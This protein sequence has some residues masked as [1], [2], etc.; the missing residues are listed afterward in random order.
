MREREEEDACSVFSTME[1]FEGERRKVMDLLCD[2]HEIPME[3]RNLV[4]VETDAT[5]LDSREDTDI[6]ETIQLNLEGANISAWEV[7]YCSQWVLNNVNKF[8]KKMGI[9]FEG[10]KYLT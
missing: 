7:K 10:M 5:F 9:S 6:V 8:N 1:D 3:T 4:V 2:K